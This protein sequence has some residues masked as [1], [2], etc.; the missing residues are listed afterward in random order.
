[1]A[2]P[3][4]AIMSAGQGSTNMAT[5]IYQQFMQLQQ[6]NA[7]YKSLSNTLGTNATINDITTGRQSAYMNEEAANQ[8]SKVREQG[9]ATRASAR[10]AMAAQGMDLSSGSAQDV[11]T[12]SERAQLDDEE[13][14]RYNNYLA[15]TENNRQGA[16]TSAQLRSQQ[17]L[18]E[19]EKRHA[20]GNAILGMAT[21]LL[22]GSAATGGNVFSAIQAQKEKDAERQEKYGK[23]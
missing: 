23:K 4:A 14:I 21:T 18:A 15:T 3:I 22:T 11:L 6:Q 12:S 10:V 9:E 13:M 19:I 8:V 5:S 20:K 17:R 2:I 16:F 7:Y 1:M